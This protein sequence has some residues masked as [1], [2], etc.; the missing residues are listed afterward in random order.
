MKAD[1]VIRAMKKA[2]GFR[3]TLVHTG[4][5]YDDAMSQAFFND[6]DMKKPDIDLEV[7][8]EK[9]SLTK[10][11]PVPERGGHGTGQAPG[12]KGDGDRL[13]QSTQ[14]APGVGDALRHAVSGRV[15]GREDL[16]SNAFTLSSQQSEGSSGSPRSLRTLRE[17][18]GSSAQ[19]AQIAEIEERFEP[20]LLKK[21][22]DWVFVYGDVNSTV[23]CARVAA[24]HGVKIAH[25]EAGLRSFDRHMPEEINRI[26]TDQLAE[27]LFVT[28]ESG[29]ENLKKEG[30]SLTEGT[31]ST[32]KRIHFVGNTMIDTVSRLLPKAVKRFKVGDSVHSVNSVKKS[33]SSAFKFQISGFP[34]RYALVTLHRP[35][36]VDDP[37]TLA[38]IM[39]QLELVAKNIHVIFPVHPRTLAMLAGLGC[40]SQR[41][42]GTPRVGDTLRHAVS[43]RVA[44]GEG[45]EL[46]ACTLP[47]QQSGGSSGS[48]RSRR[49]LREVSSIVFLPPAGYLDFLALQA[50][51]AVVVTDSGG[52]QEETSYLGVPCLTVRNN[53]ERPVTIERGTN[54]L[55]KIAQ[56]RKSVETVLRQNEQNGQNKARRKP[57][58]PRWDGH[59]AER[60]V[61]VMKS[62]DGITHASLCRAMQGTAG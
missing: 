9:R 25:V 7:G 26:E 6:L 44:D 48:P 23:A 50:N 54:R 16:E 36:N 18:S 46:N 37:K 17:T 14:G 31:K 24:K 41:S 58:I 47:S 13:S 19:A 53:T 10:L 35:S 32:K 21:K 56:I 57:R 30:I 22:P 38:R 27:L 29:M 45:F 11:T 20:V 42:Q 49:T 60:I 2:G 3:Q 15:T 5:H 61:K 33:S 55:I 59:A 4:Q 28:E 12:T 34:Q 8:R 39:K 43:G 51:A 52:I 1:P 40:L 62:L